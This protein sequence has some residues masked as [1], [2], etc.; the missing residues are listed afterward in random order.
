MNDVEAYLAANFN[1]YVGELKAFCAIPSI[2]TDPIFAKSV[3]G[4]AT[5]TADRLHRAGFNRVELFETDGHPLVLGE[6]LGALGAATVVV[7]GH[8][9]VQP[10]DPIEKWLTP[11]FEPTLRN[12]RLYARGASDDKGPLLIPILV[13]EG[14]P[15]IARHAAAECEDAD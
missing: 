10:P 13:A 6:W 5:F 12:N 1:S 14:I 7:Y 15:E 4:A 2:S 3:R 9:D 8:Y 11:P